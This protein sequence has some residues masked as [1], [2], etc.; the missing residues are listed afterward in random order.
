[1]LGNCVDVQIPCMDWLSALLSRIEGAFESHSHV[2]I[3]ITRKRIATR[4]TAFPDQSGKVE[5]SERQAQEWFSHEQS[6]VSHVM[7]PV[8]WIGTWSGIGSR[9]AT[10]KGILVSEPVDHK[11]ER[12]S[13]STCGI[14]A[15]LSV[16]HHAFSPFVQA[17][18]KRLQ[19]SKGNNKTLWRPVSSSSIPTRRR[20]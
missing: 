17:S 11:P 20:A 2:L 10:R 13:V 16:H 4:D 19:S 7:L 15:L 14:F 3:S 5:C 9:R 8:S 12:S 1:M 6:G 18:L